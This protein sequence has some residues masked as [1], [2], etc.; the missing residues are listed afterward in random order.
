MSRLVEI[1]TSKDP[2]I[3]DLSLDKE[4]KDMPIKYLLSECEVLEKMRK[5]NENLYEKVRGLFFLYAI[6][7][8][9]I[10]LKSDLDEK[11]IIPY[12]A[13]EHILN[14]RFEEAID[15]LQTKQREHGANRGLS[16]ALAEAYKKL[17]FQ[18]LADQVRRSVR[19]TLG[20]QW[21]FRTGHPHDHPLV[22]KK[23][24]LIADRETGLYPVLH[25][26]TPVRMDISHSGW[27]D[28][29]F[30]GMDYPEGANVLNIS[31]DLSVRDEN[32]NAPKPPI[33]TFFRIIE[34]P[35]LRLTSVDLGV[36][37]DISKLADVFD[38]AKDYL[39]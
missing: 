19:S 1:I 7:R 18:T 14:R 35:V 10:P 38:F 32:E 34:E 31:I 15:I 16:S 33:E 8:F 2:K 13:Y 22:I 29:F 28:I 6:H 37:T 5:E 39:G 26:V 25:E 9:H 17:A 21:M 24:L 3:R 27:S 12:V 20:N 23:E 30:L 36:T 4:C 11:S